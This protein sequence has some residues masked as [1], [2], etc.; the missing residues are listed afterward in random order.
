MNELK[1]QLKDF[2]N[3]GFIHPSVSPWDAL[4]LFVCKKDGSIHICIDYRQINKVVVK[5]IYPLPSIDY[6][7]DQLQR[8]KC[9]SKID[10]RLGY[11]Q[12]KIRD[13]DIP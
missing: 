5:N 8:A 13:A 3:K 2:L 7:F 9:L 1:K 6:L 10:L 4:V 12:L 11:N